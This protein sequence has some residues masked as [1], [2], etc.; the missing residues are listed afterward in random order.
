MAHVVFDFQYGGLENGVV[1]LVNKLPKDRYQHTIIALQEIGE[2]SARVKDNNVEFIG[3]RKKPGKDLPAYVRVY[4]ALKT[5]QPD[6]LHTRNLGTLDCQVLGA[7]IGIPKRIHSEHGWDTDDP[8]GTRKKNVIRRKVLALFVHRWI[9]LSKE[10]ETW[11]RTVIGIRGNVTRICNGVDTDRYKPREQ[12]HSQ[13]VHI[14]SV[15]RFSEIKNPLATI[16]AFAALLDQR[17]EVRLHLTM[18]GDGPLHASAIKLAEELAIS[19]HVS[20]PGSALDVSE[21][22]SQFDVFVL[23]SHREGISNTILEAM[24]AGVP[25]IATNVGGS[26]ELVTPEDN[27]FLV[28]P[29]DLDGLVDAMCHLVDDPAKMRAF[30]TNSRETAVNKFSLQRMVADYDQQYSEK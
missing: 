14:G 6:V 13:C 23:P 21:T 5:I 29:N 2:I 18:I 16:K 30:A 4:Q 26:S 1:N 7:L 25:V 24:A 27:G 8:F 10:I 11:L 20:L 12:T 28:S 15:T 17:S 22:V 9:A 3:I 19:D